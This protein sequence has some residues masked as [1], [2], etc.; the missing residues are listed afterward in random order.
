MVRQEK[1]ILVVNPGSASR[2]Y[3]LYQNQSL[4]GSLHFE[5][6]DQ[7]IVAYLDF[8][9]KRQK[10]DVSL[11]KIEESLGVV[12]GIFEHFGVIPNGRMI[13]A[14]VLRI[15]APGD[16]FTKSRLVDDSFMAELNSITEDAPLHVPSVKKE[17]ALLK[18]AF[19]KLPVVAVSDSAFH[20][21]R[22]RVMNHY[23]ISPGLAKKHGIKRFGFHGFSVAS[24]AQ[25][26]KSNNLL[27]DKVI[28]AHLGSGSSVT[29]LYRGESLDNSMGFSPLEGLAM[30]TRSGDIDIMAALSIKRHLGLT[31]SGLIS[32]LN[33]KSGLFGLSGKSGDLRDLLALRNDGDESASLAVALFSH[34]VQGM[35]GR[36]AAE[37]NGVDAL[38]F[39]GTVGQR[40]EEIRRSIVSKL[41]YLGFSIDPVKNLVEVE[42]GRK[43][44]SGDS[45]KPIYAIAT[46]EASQMVL[47]AQEV[48]AT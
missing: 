43:V 37:L 6:N 27:T 3:A 14:A 32:Y 31:D 13:N 12:P 38:V 16:Y 48:L 21:N 28:V 30:A 42:S 35:I 5:F 23:A 45:S 36:M 33:K 41:T 26:L 39:T 40:S 8:N 15:V 46:D 1:V 17:L 29:A 44:I 19:P 24:I 22:A 11:D 25:H 9:K 47:A 10:I 4:L 2:K 18:K 7:K 34:R 20:A